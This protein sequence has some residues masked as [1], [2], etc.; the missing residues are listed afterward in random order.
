VT[1]VEVV[2]FALLTLVGLIHS[3]L[4]SGTETGLYT[5]NRVRLAVRA[6]QGDRAALRVRSLRA[7]PG[8]MLATV[9]VGNNIANYGVSYGIAAFMATTGRSPWQEIA[10]N[11]LVLV[12][13]LVIFGEILPKDLFRLNTD[14]WTYTMSGFLSFWSNLLWFTGLSLLVQA[15]GRGASALLGVKDAEAQSARDRISRLIR[16][17]VGA[18]VLSEA[19][20]NLAERALAMRNRIVAQEMVSWSRVITIKERATARARAA[21]VRKRNVT[22]LPVVTKTGDVI[23]TVSTLDLVLNP[24]SPVRELMQPALR[25]PGSMPVRDALRTLRAD[26]KSMAIVTD[27][28]GGRVIGLVTLKDLVEPL[29][30]ELA[31]W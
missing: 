31:V 18:G 19:Q 21:K 8:R 27:V 3:A 29:T 30:G 15:V 10:V 7:R 6:A 23:G 16:E 11:A 20:T 1:P 17:G 22:R 26:R 25:I 24:E 9:L 13:L 14:R 5:I 12:P 4:F 28:P 2:L